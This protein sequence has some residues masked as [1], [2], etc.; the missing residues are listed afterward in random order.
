MIGFEIIRV[1]SNVTKGNVFKDDTFS[2][3]YDVPVR[4]CTRRCFWISK[5]TWKFHYVKST[6]NMS[7]NEE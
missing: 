4:K 7:V 1:S 3:V 6:V 5:R 2:Y